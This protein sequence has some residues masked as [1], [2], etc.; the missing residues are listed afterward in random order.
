MCTICMSLVVPLK[1]QMGHN[2]LRCM[3]QRK[4]EEGSIA[5]LVAQGCK[6]VLKTAP[7]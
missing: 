2:T 5:T 3:R 1:A 4:V 7:K 6:E